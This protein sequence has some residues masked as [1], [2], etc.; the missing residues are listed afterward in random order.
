[1]VESIGGANA[2]TGAHVHC[3]ME[4]SSITY[5]S[6]PGSGQ[7]VIDVL[8]LPNGVQV[9]VNTVDANGGI[10]AATITTRGT[11]TDPTT[12]TGIW[13]NRHEQQSTTGSGTG[14]HF[15]IDF[16]VNSM[17][18]DAAGSGG[19][20]TGNVLF[21]PSQLIGCRFEGTWYTY[22]RHGVQDTRD[23]YMERSICCTTRPRTPT[24]GQSRWPLGRQRQLQVRRDR[25]RQ[26]PAGGGSNNGGAA[27]SIDTSSVFQNR[28]CKVWPDPRPGRRLAR[29]GR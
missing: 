18:T 7:Q 4:A 14:A 13:G 23:N 9:T 19:A 11:T 3:V 16:R 20:A 29:P 24:D 21:R 26:H 6:G 25:R 28:R 10:T 1:M 12:G 2:L 8:T 27:L 5:I 17:V 22:G 15:I